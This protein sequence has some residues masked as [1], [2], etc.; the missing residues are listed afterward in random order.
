MFL[1]SGC[2]GVLLVVLVGPGLDPPTTAG[3]APHEAREEDPPTIAGQAS[4]EAR[5]DPPGVL[6]VEVLC[7]WCV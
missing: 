1:P 2:V 5:E 6:L 4:C 3:Q 7:R